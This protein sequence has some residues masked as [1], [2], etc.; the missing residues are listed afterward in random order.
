M[1]FEDFKNDLGERESSNNYYIVNDFGYLGRWQFGKTRLFDLGI[2]INGYCPK[3]WTLE[4]KKIM[5]VGEFLQD[6][7]LQDRIFKK[8]VKNILSY[9]RTHYKEAI[10]KYTESGLVAGVHLKGFGGLD[11]FLKGEDNSDAFGTK[12]SEYIEQFK[13]YDLSEIK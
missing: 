7:K 12:I 13:G 11:K 5:T 2:S 4:G 1:N 6:E 9:L 10:E 3:G 8:H